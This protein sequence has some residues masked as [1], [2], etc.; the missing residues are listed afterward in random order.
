MN[1]VGSNGINIS[2]WDAC[3]ITLELEECLSESVASSQMLLKV[4]AALSRFPYDA[5][6][7][8]ANLFCTLLYQQIS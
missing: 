3:F 8:D 5:N 1:I 4:Y 7:L 6:F 2:I